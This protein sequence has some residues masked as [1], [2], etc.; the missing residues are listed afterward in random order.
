M[1]W[2]VVGMF[3]SCSV[4][5]ACGTASSFSAARRVTWS[6]TGMKRGFGL[7]GS[8]CV[9]RRGPGPN[10]LR[11]GI[12]RIELSSVCIVRMI[13]VRRDHLRGKSGRASLR[14][15]APRIVNRNEIESAPGP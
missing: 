5:P 3:S 13:T 10:R 14:R 12:R 15:A 4:R 8:S 11:L 1:M 9:C 6:A 7:S 2:A